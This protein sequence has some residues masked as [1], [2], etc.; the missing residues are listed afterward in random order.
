[1]KTATGTHYL[2]HGYGP[3]WSSGIPPERQLAESIH[4]DETTFAGPI[5][6]ITAARGTMPDGTKWRYLGTFGESIFY[7]TKDPAA[8]V[9]LD[10]IMDR[11]C[12]ARI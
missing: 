8:A 3:K 9:K 5:S 4:Y 2:T 1:M 12:L 11:V 7:Q 6:N 10:A